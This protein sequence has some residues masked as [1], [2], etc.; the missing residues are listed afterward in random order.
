MILS[1]FTK[2]QLKLT[3]LATYFEVFSL[4]SVIEFSHINILPAAILVDQFTNAVDCHSCLFSLSSEHYY[5]NLSFNKEYLLF[6]SG[7][8]KASSK[9]TQCFSHAGLDFEKAIDLEWFF[10]FTVFPLSRIT[11]VFSRDLP[12]KEAIKWTSPLFKTSRGQAEG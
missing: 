10:H 5:T 12:Y 1:S 7:F 8:Y 4:H 6:I 2:Q 9:L 11:I 3:C